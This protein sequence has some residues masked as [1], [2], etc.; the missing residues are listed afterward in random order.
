M[1]PAVTHAIACPA[2][3]TEHAGDTVT[4]TLGFNEAVTVAGTPTLS[5]NDG[6]TAAYVGGSRSEERRVGTTCASSG[7]NTP[8]VDISG[9]NRPSGASIKDASGVAA[10]LSGAVKTFS[11]L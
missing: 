10:D 6:A 2:T 4:L 9:V 8:A 1:S 5:L 3:G 7:T 11:A